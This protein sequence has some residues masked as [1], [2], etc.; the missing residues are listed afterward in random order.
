ME[1]YGKYGIGYA[2]LPCDGFY[3]MGPE[4]AARCAA[5]MKAKRVVP[6]HSSP[7]GAFDE[8]KA[9]AVGAE[10]LL[11]LKPGEKAELGD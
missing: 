8:K 6:I 3:N 5:A 2:L 1:G 4:E 10:G 7:S 9:R 11:V